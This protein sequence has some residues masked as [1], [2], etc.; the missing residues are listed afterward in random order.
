MRIL[1]AMSGGVDSSAVCL[2]LQE[3]GYEVVGMTMRV[4][5]LPRQFAHAATADGTLPACAQGQVADDALEPDFILSARSLAER[6]GIEHHVVDVREEFRDTVVRY[7]LDEYEAGRTPNP[8][9]L[10]NRAFK[11]RLLAEL[12]DRLGCPLMATGHYVQTQEHNGHTYLLMGDDVRKDQSYFLWR[13]PQE[14]LGRMRFPLGT[15]AKPDVRAYLDRCGFAVRA[16]QAESME[17]CFVENDYRDFLRQQRPATAARV[18]GGYFVDTGG[19]RLGTHHGVPFYTVGQRKGLGIALGQPAYV[20]RLNAE[21]NTIVLGSETDLSTH[22][23]LVE[24]LECVSRNEVLESQELTVRIRYHSQPVACRVQI[25]DDGRCLVT[26][27]QS[28][29]AVSPGQSTVFYIGRRLVGGAIIAS[30]RG[31]GGIL[32]AMDC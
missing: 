14:V 22:H 10:C 16:R 13:V 20:L 9:V 15:M 12:A 6:L 25:L 3:Q 27:S 18:D 23:L 1:V 28:V 32:A 24:H 7:F 17:V 31:I 26:T 8:C 4:W 5:D 30:Q 19:K 21:K 29:S 2:L 11:F